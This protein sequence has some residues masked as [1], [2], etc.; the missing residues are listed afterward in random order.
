MK[1]LIS[2]LVDQAGIEEKVAEKV[3]G[4]V[5]EFLEDKLPAPIAG[6]VTKLL[7]GMDDD[8]KDGM[9]DMAKGLFGK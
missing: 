6:Q 2:K 8:K 1:E 3:V 7:S 4:L 5:K 9:M